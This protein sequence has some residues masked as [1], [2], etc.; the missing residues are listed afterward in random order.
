MS[1]EVRFKV[2]EPEKSTEKSTKNKFLGIGLEI[3]LLILCDIIVTSFKTYYHTV[4]MI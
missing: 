2:D 3:L 4:L 1:L